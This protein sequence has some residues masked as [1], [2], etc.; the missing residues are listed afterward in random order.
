[1]HR[2]SREQ[3]EGFLTQYGRYGLSSAG[4]ALICANS[5]DAHRK[6]KKNMLVST[7]PVP[8][9]AEF[10]DKRVL[11]TG[12]TKGAGRAIAERFLSGGGTV[13]VSAR[14]SPEEQTEAYFIQADLSTGDGASKVIR[15]VLN[16]FK[17]VDILVHN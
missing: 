6:G 16:R 12:G 14:S 5:I 9:A 13:I 1:M 4:F 3:A 10:K 17:G 7:L 15:E 2:R 8:D 11:V